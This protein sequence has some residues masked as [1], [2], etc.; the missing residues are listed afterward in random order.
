VD[1]TGLGWTQMQNLQKIGFNILAA[2]SRTRVEEESFITEQQHEA[3]HQHRTEALSKT[4]HPHKRGL[5][6]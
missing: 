6:Q 1:R 2:S 5:K 3:E 4:E